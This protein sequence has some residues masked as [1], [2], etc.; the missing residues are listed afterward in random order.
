MQT[1]LTSFCEKNAGKKLAV[2]LCPEAVL[3][4]LPDLDQSPPILRAPF[5]PSLCEQKGR[6]YILRQS[7]SFAVM[8]PFGRMQSLPSAFST[9]PRPI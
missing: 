5:V 7:P 6:I 2:E 8:P 4:T 1:T 3:F 9:L